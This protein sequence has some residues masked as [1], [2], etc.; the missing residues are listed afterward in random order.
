M[1][2]CLRRTRKLN[3]KL[4]DVSLDL[5]LVVEG[6]TMWDYIKLYRNAELYMEGLGQRMQ[7][8]AYAVRTCTVHVQG[9]G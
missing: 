1:V 4:N 2:T 6:I 7:L 9:G 5:A 8:H 3:D